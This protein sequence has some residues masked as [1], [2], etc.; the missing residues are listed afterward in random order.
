MTSPLKDLN[1]YFTNQEVLRIVEAFGGDIVSAQKA[2]KEFSDDYTVGAPCDDLCQIGREDTKMNVESLAVVYAE[3][4]DENLLDAWQGTPIE[5]SDS[6]TG[7]NPHYLTYDEK[8]DGKPEMTKQFR[9][10]FRLPVSEADDFSEKLKTAG[11]TNLVL[12]APLF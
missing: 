7:G 12:E 1:D 11:F 8:D 9:L 3:T 4:D 6:F 10:M 2:H 5:F